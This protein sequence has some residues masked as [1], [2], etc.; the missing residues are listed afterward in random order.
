MGYDELARGMER[1]GGE[2]KG[3][4][5]QAGIG[6]ERRRGSPR[7]EVIERDLYER[8]EAVPEIRG[9]VYVDRSGHREK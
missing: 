4:A 9:K 6:R 1:V 3:G 8:E 2:V 7:A 5:V